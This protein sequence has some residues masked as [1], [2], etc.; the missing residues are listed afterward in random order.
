MEYILVNNLF[1]NMINFNKHLV[2]PI[3]DA[4][5]FDNY[6]NGPIY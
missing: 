3:L 6:L 1:Y 5:E 4:L 2:L